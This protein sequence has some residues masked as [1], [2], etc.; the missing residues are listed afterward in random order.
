MPGRFSTFWRATYDRLAWS[1]ARRAVDAV[2]Y[3]PRHLDLVVA[4]GLNQPEVT[5]PVARWV[6]RTRAT[7]AVVTALEVPHRLVRAVARQAADR[8][9]PTA[10]ALVRWFSGAVAAL[11]DGAGAVTVERPLRTR[12]HPGLLVP[13][14][15]AVAV[16]AADMRGFSRLTG[17]LGDTQYLSRLIEEYL[18][19]LTD[20]VEQHRGVVFQ[21]TGD[22]LL[23]L[24]LPEL[25]GSAGG[26]MLDRLVNEMSPALHVA[27][28]TLYARWRVEWFESARSAAAIGLGLGLSYGRATIGFIGPAGKK[29]FG[30]LGDPV[31][32]A[33]LLAAQ[34]H[35][36]VLLVDQASFTR[37]DSP[38][39]AGRVV[40]IR[41]SKRRERVPALALRFGAAA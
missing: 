39:P 2:R 15:H 26:P 24:F 40:R 19:A 28:E 11:A 38:P 13:H 29:Q 27:F 37:A 30:V 41:S 12:V 17:V 9:G 22:G 3:Q 34:A 18:T 25:A 8:F 16:L 4:C 21:Y 32:L 5:L 20:V 1:I 31:N 35:A 14:T 10:S 33:A 23:A 6:A 7:P 36:G